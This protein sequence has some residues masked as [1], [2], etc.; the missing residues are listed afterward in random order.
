MQT[1]VS[2]PAT[3]IWIAAGVYCPNGVPI[4][5]T[6]KSEDRWITNPARGESDANGLLMKQMPG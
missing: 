5:I 2:A 6:A 3:A 1:A 4:S